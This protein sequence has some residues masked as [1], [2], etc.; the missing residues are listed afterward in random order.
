[1]YVVLFI[2]IISIF[3]IFNYINIK[4]NKELVEL[5]KKFKLQRM[6]FEE[7]FKNSRDGIVIIDNKDRIINVNESFEKIFQYKFEEIKG[8]F[9]NDVIASFNIEDAFQFSNIIMHGGT[10][11]AETKRKRKDGSLVDVNIIAFP[12]IF[13]TNQVGLCAM[14]KDIGYKKS[15]NR[16]CN[17]RGFILVNF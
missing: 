4:K 3:F 2:A 11:N 12:F 14:Y 6:Y 15:Q 16:N 7:L 10:V 8:L 9:A 5:N 1:M 13:D 17:C